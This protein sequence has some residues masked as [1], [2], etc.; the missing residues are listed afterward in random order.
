MKNRVL[1]KWIVKAG[2]FFLVG[3]TAYRGGLLGLGSGGGAELGQAP[4]RLREVGAEVGAR[5]VHRATNVDPRVGNIDAQITAV[6]AAVSIADPNGD[7]WP[8]LFALTSAEGE[9]SALFVNQGDGTF[10]DRA[11]DSGLADLNRPGEGCAMGSTWAD[12][13]GDGDQDVFVYGWGTCRLFRNDGGLRFT[14]VS[15][16]SGLERRMNSNAATWFDYDRDGVL[17]LFVTGY[18]A[19]HHDLWDLSTTRIMHDSFEFANN[20]GRNYLYRGAGD[21]TF[22]DVSADSELEGTR[23]TY[24]AV[25][26]DFDRDGWRDLYLANDYGT[27]QLLLNRA[28]KRFELA[29]DVGLEGES[30]SGM[31]VALGEL[32]GQLAVYVTNISRRGY[33]FQ[34]NNLRLAYLDA[35]QGMIQVAE[36]PVLD[37]GWAW[38]A[39]FGDLDSDGY[40]DLVVGNGFISASTERDYWYQ[41]SKIGLATGDLIADAA[42][43]PAFEDRSLSGY[44]RTQV[45][46]N[47]GGRGMRFREIG[48]NAGVSEVHDGRAVALGDLFGSGRLDVVIANQNGPL[49]I[50]RNESPQ[51]AGSW[52]AFDLVGGG[53]NPDAIGGEVEIRHG[54]RTQLRVITAASGFAGQNDRRVR[55][56]LGSGVATVEATVR[57][58]SGA[59]QELVDLATD[60]M[61]TLR[62]AT[63]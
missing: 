6:G 59:E 53:K 7:G 31:C 5:F 45:L 41:M 4:I 40:Q 63:P 3:Y 46:R 27:E 56:G 50:Y 14:E 24:A 35:G 1:R 2:F 29:Q 11:A 55:F 44:E 47:Q 39:Q 43:W 57:W 9:P 13:D 33:L 60:R 20:G 26:A 62:E 8:D 17:D 37:C 30:K 18:F 42:Q 58:P 54:D 12:Y 23:W 15:Q 34:G 32:G 10:V 21:G 19:E 28:G 51:P 22:V 16:G 38:G 52:I 25:A 49:L 48:L 61:H 36:G